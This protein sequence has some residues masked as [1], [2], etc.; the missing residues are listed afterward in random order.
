MLAAGQHSTLQ[1]RQNILTSLIHTTFHHQVV[2]GLQ[3]TLRDKQRYTTVPL[4]KIHSEF[5]AMSFH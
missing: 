3:D 4:T 2:L 5:I 1:V